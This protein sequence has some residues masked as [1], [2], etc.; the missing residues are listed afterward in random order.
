MNTKRKI[1]VVPC[2]LILCLI[3]FVAVMVFGEEKE[4]LATSSS[5]SWSENFSSAEEMLAQADVA[6]IGILSS[7]Y[8]ELRGSLVFTRNVVEVVTVYSGDVQVGDT[9]EVL[10]TGGTYGDTTT[11]AFSEVPLLEAGHLYALSLTETEPDEDYG[12]YYLIMGGPQGL[13]TAE[14]APDSMDSLAEA[15]SNNFY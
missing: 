13:A 9:I 10:Q 4:P 15:F 7:S 1:K 2:I 14:N 8:T 11:P 5:A 6:I 3:V 12:Q